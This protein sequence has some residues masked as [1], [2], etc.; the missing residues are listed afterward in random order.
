MRDPGGATRPCPLC[1]GQELRLVFYPPLARCRRCGLVF[2]TEY[3]VRRA[4]PDD[5]QRVQG[6]RSV[7]YREFLARYR[8]VPGGNRLLDVGC[9]TGEF[10]RLARAAGWDVLGVEIAEE[11]VGAARAAGLP[12]RPG[13]LASL[14]LPDTSFQVITFWDVLDWV[15]DPME[16]AREANRLL[17]S[18]GILML[19]VRNLAFHSAVYRLSRLVGWWPRLALPLARQ[20]VFHQVSFNAST[21]RRI[22]AEAGFG[23]IEITNSAPSWG[24]PYASLPRGGDRLLQFAKRSV[25]GVTS[26]IA[27]STAGRLLWGSSLL[28]RAVKG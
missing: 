15:S 28:A 20:Y 4:R 11:A 5:H 2:R 6:R 10:L 21:L 16:Q 27:I 12:I 1:G 24:D 9:G 3:E 23:R 8:P 14:R 17:V 13:S 25:S 7:L 18:G 22:L 26:L 19:R